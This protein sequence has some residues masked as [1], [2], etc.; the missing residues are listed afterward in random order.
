[1]VGTPDDSV[2]RT[3][4]TFGVRNNYGTTTSPASG[5]LASP[6]QGCRVLRQPRGF[7]G[8]VR[9]R[10][11]SDLDPAPTGARPAPAIPLQSVATA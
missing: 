11:D 9:P 4:T 2:D 3:A 8:S 5:S 10:L 7:E 6:C 1:M